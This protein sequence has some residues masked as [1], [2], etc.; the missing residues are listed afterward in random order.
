MASRTFSEESFRKISS[1]LSRASLE[2]F[3]LWGL[4][5]L[6]PKDTPKRSH[7]SFS[8][9][10]SSAMNLVKVTHLD[11]FSLPLRVLVLVPLDFTYET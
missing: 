8:S 11:M 6:V 7:C 4:W 1:G 2:H 9:A 3:F 10:F 5:F